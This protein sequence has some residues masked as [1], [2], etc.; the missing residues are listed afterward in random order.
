MPFRCIWNLL[1]DL[2]ARCVVQ[3]PS[4]TT[5][6]HAEGRQD[7]ACPKE[8][9]PKKCTCKASITLRRNGFGNA[10]GVL[11]A[12]KCALTDQE[13]HA[14]TMPIEHLRVLSRYFN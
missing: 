5:F 1:P 7:T 8:V 12:R 13:A 3:P 2:I 6:I 10:P 4:A 9:S 14:R 11:S